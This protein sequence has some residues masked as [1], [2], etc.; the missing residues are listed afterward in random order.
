MK[1]LIDFDN[2]DTFPKE[3][4]IWDAGFEKYIDSNISLDGVTEWW[5][6]KDQLQ[7]LHIEGKRIVTQFLKNNMETEVVVS[8]C[9]RVLDE[10]SYWKQGLIISGG[11]GSLEE[12]RI[13]KLLVQIGVSEDMIEK[14][15][16][17]IYLYWNRD[18][19]SRTKSV[20]FCIDKKYIYNDYKISNY[21]INLGGEILRW[22]IE[23]INKDLYK[24]EPYKRLW[25]LGKPCIVKFKCS[26]S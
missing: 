5:Q 10:E 20:H 12:Q 11:Q 19:K 22:S 16:E 15:F 18:R 3:L 7:S 2:P 6:I 25:I 14:I 24:Q 4:Q 26:A 23:G 8:H 1:K 9:T 17:H 13:R 21:A